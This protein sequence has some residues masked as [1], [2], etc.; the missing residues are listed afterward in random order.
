MSKFLR[1]PLLSIIAFCAYQALF[2]FSNPNMSKGSIPLR[3]EVVEVEAGYGYLIWAGEKLLVKQEF[4]PAINGKVPFQSYA[5]AKKVAVLVAFKF[6]NRTNPEVSV[7]ELS[8]LNIA[9]LT[10]E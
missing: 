5:D 6:K 10:R 4:I 2:N 9:T 8:R 7:E 1:I 3:S